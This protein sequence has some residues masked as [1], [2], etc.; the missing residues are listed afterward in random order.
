MGI[1]IQLNSGT[2]LVLDEAESIKVLELV[3]DLIIDKVK[4]QLKQS[5]C[6]RIL[7][8]NGSVY[9]CLREMGHEPDGHRFELPDVDT[10]L[11]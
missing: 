3:T 4:K 6:N 5:Q 11:R 9:Y 2:T 1:K 10:V 7:W 8:H